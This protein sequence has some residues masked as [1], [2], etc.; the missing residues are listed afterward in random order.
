V[1]EAWQVLKQKVVGGGGFGKK[2]AQALGGGLLLLGKA[3]LRSSY[4]IMGLHGACGVGG[5]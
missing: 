4:E 3:R 1:V 2:P 5:G